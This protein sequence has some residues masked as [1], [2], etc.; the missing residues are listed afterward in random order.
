MRAQIDKEHRADALAWQSRGS[1]ARGPARSR[2]WG[3]FLPLA[4]TSCCGHCTPASARTA[5]T[6]RPAFF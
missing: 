5:A 1:C 6:L 3:S 2:I 4:C